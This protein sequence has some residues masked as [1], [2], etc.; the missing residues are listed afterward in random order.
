MEAGLLHDPVASSKAEAAATEGA[1]DAE[2]VTAE[3]VVVDA[4][5]VETADASC[6]TESRPRRRRLRVAEVQCPIRK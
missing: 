2:G 3:E 1:V 6:A 5:G 4:E